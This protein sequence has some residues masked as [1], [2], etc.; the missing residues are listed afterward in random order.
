MDIG[1]PTCPDPQL[2]KQLK[3]TRVELAKMSPPPVFD[4]NAKMKPKMNQMLI[5]VSLKGKMF[6]I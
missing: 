2:R 1:L 3:D 4:P 5:I 6:V